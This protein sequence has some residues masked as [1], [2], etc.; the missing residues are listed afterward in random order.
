[1]DRDISPPP[2]KRR[3][4]KPATTQSAVPPASLRGFLRRHHWPAMLL[5]QEVKIAT[6]DIKTQDAVRAAVNASSSANSK[7]PAYEAHFTL[8]NDAYNAKGLRGSG[9]VYG[10]CSILRR[11]LREKYSVNVH[12]VD[13]DN[14]GR[15]SIVKIAR[16]RQRLAVFNIYAVNGTD[17]P[18]RDS[19]T[20]AQ[21]GTRHDHKLAF[22]KALAEECKRWEGNGWDVLLGGDMNVAPD[23]R[24][25]FPKLRMFPMQ[26]VLNRADFHDKLLQGKEGKEGFGGVDVWRRIHGEKRRYTYYSRGREWGTSCDRVDYFIAGRR[27][28]DAKMIKDGGILDSEAERGSSDHV[29]IWVDI[30]LST[31]EADQ[32]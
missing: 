10:V 14:E 31:P 25:G 27:A 12:T 5:L 13:W 17:N 1:M 28:W 29:P 15:I 9:K 18:Y 7:E 22:H 19:R 30:A 3:K 2:A 26:H 8:P 16:D 23:A 11:D 32:Y 24:D 6:K 4:V 21:R 20:G